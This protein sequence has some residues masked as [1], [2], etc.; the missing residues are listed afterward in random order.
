MLPVYD[1]LIETVYN[2][3]KLF[4]NKYKGEISMKKL[5]WLLVLLLACCFIGC[6]K[7]DESESS[8]KDATEESGEET[9]EKDDNDDD[10]DKKDKKTAAGHE[11]SAD[12]VADIFGLWYD[13]NNEWNLL[14]F[15][16][17][18]EDFPN[19]GR[20]V[21]T[22]GYE[23]YLLCLDE[24]GRKGKDT[25]GVC[26]EDGKSY[27]A[28][29]TF[30]EDGILLD[31]I[32][33]LGTGE[34]TFVRDGMYDSEPVGGNRYSTRYD[35]DFR[36]IQQV[37]GDGKT[38][39]LLS[40]WDT[41]EYVIAYVE[42]EDDTY[43][44]DSF[45]CAKEANVFYEQM[46]KG[47]PVV[48]LVNYE[49]LSEYDF[50]NRYYGYEDG[51]GS[52]YEEEDYTPVCY[53]PKEYDWS[54][55]DEDTGLWVVANTTTNRRPFKMTGVELLEWE[56]KYIHFIGKIKNEGSKTYAGSVRIYLCDEKGETLKTATKG[57]SFYYL[58]D[59]YT[60]N[61]QG[62]RMIEEIESALFSNRAIPAGEEGIFSINGAGYLGVD[63]SE[64]TQPIHYIYI[65]LDEYWESY[66]D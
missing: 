3:D 29:M 28:N 51:A 30:T 55:Y 59:G 22:N 8:K 40:N 39:Y 65:V 46:L 27:K 4:E 54:Y 6:G 32:S 17:D 42:N 34:M 2:I 23:E 47:F 60:I 18:Y 44:T 38:Y 66:D 5:K 20:A 10:E 15:N 24:K 62:L 36:V 63:V 37:I 56:S 13:K 9:K 50:Y 1:F 12:N 53:F 7:S 41:G 43:Y 61:G 25:I 45:F 58:P 35:A 26:D 57:S 14:I 64:I 33:K 19:I 31:S 48:Q 21:L 16:N 11:V 49:I 52:E